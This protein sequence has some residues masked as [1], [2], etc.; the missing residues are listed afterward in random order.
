MKDDLLPRKRILDA[1]DRIGRYINN[2]TFEQ[3]K[4]NEQLYDSV[5]M[6]LI[7]IGEEANKVSDTFKE[8]HPE[9]PWHKMIGMRNLISHDY[10]SLKPEVVWSTAQRDVPKLRKQI[11]SLT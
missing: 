1:A 10:F 8:E 9:T 4:K 7:V 3:F 5:L 2:T 11:A 6:N